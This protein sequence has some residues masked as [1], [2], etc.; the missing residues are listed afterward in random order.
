VTKS[1]DI[2]RAPSRR[3]VIKA[4]GAIALGLAA[5][6]FLR[7]GSALAAY[8]DRA[9]KIVVA[10]TPGGPSD[11]SA[12]MIA[13]E[14]QQIMGASVF[15]ENKGGA[16]GNIGYGYAARS[17]PDGYTILLTTSAYV[18][19]PGLYN[20]I[21][22]D[23]FKDFV[24]ICE[25]VVSPHVFTVKGDNKAKDMKEL[26]AMVKANPDRFNI[27][28]PPIGTT[29]Q[30]QAEV[31]KMRAGLEKM[32]TVVYK[33]GGDAIKALIDGTVQISSGTLAP[34]FPHMKA[35]TLKA[36]SQTG[37]SRWVGLPNVPTMIEQG[38]KDF[39]FE[40]YCAL[41]APAK[42]PPE[43]VAKLEKTILD[44]LAKPEM[45]KKLVDAGFDVVA[46]NAKDH[47]ARIAKE[48]PMFK[49][50][51]EKAKIKKL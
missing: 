19:N 10:N 48:V 34:A 27:S 22:Y 18:V 25:P 20:S 41:V 45:K 1:N 35:G 50:V 12:R 29:P 5:P 24:P 6:T 23:P 44:I 47:G 9:I 7:I 21:P 8:P 32:P 33:G 39:V 46:R 30:L 15:V 2:K 37:Q 28:T 4:G 38:Y 11:I 43:I 40:T 17:E 26:V 51:I 31:F 13:A 3:R 42:V 49:D 16:G 14:M 36:L